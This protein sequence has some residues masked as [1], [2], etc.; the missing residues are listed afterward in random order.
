MDPN[1]V[2][3][4]D[5]T[6]RGLTAD[7]VGRVLR[8]AAELDAVAT[9]SAEGELVSPEI[10]VA[11]GVEAGLSPVAVR[12]AL[13]ELAIDRSQGGP[14]PVEP[15]AAPGLVGSPRLTVQREV[16]GSAADVRAALHRFLRGQLFVPGRVA[17]DRS[18]W[19]PRRG[20]T[21]ALRRVAD[22]NRRL[23]LEDVHALEVAVHPVPGEG[24]VVV[25]VEADVVGIRRS[26]TA[27]LAGGTAAGASAGTLIV[28]ATGLAPVAI[29]ALPVGAG[30][31]VGG[32]LAG[33]SV[34]RG[35]AG[36]VHDAIAGMLDRLEHP[37]VRT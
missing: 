32:H 31:A 20:V 8:R 23:Q 4:L 14:S 29:V 12:R 16:P 10:V 24:L 25:T 1:T 18:R 17:P 36:R 11:A 6:G 28:L 3:H 37:D 30:L 19:V 2:D 13:A 5:V 15:A 22:L 27:W 21:A 26:Q 33:R 7:E 9:S 35:R 34:Y